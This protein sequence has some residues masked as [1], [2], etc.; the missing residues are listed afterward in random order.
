MLGEFCYDPVD[1]ESFGKRNRK[2]LSYNG[3]YKYL[4]EVKKVDFLQKNLQ[5]MEKGFKFTMTVVA[6]KVFLRKIKWQAKDGKSTPMEESILV[7]I[8][9]ATKKELVFWFGLTVSG[10][11]ANGERIKLKVLEPWSIK[12]V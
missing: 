5:D 3:G 12:M 2:I 8:T 7:I 10:M 4:G 6:S 1:D 11:K 9:M